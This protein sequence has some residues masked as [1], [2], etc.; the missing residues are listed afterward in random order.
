MSVASE[1]AKQAA[2]QLA[3]DRAEMEKNNL[4]QM[5]ELAKIQPTPTI[6]EVQKSLEGKNWTPKKKVVEPAAEVVEE[7]KAVDAKPNAKGYETR[8]ATSKK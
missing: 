1:A 7:K 2:D 3:K 4:K 6:E 8:E 5:E